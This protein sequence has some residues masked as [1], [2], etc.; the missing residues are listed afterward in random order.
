MKNNNALFN[1]IINETD[2]W[3]SD[4]ENISSLL[5]D[6]D[7]DDGCV[8]DDEDIDLFEDDN[9][10]LIEPQIVNNNN[11]RINK[12]RKRCNID[13]DNES[14]ELNQRSSKRRK[15]TIIVSGQHIYIY[16]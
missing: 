14:V 3:C 9:I 13:S 4:D 10:E 6:D 12:K 2:A 5:F 7:D 15:L 1:N 16:T 11:D 8:A